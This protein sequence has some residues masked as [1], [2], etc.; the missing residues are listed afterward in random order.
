MCLFL[1]RADPHFLGFWSE[2]IWFSSDAVERN[3]QKPQWVTQDRKMPIGCFQPW[4]VDDCCT[5]DSNTH[6][7][8]FSVY[9][10]EQN[11]DCRW[12]IPLSKHP[13]LNTP[14]SKPQKCGQCG[15]VIQSESL[16]ISNPPCMVQVSALAILDLAPIV[17]YVSGFGCDI[18]IIAIRA[19]K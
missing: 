11:S 6:G 18:V 8:H 16:H 17:D 7:F 15:E 1:H 2:T 14:F 3:T 13:T 10:Q 19:R 12:D 9:T 5:C 4:N